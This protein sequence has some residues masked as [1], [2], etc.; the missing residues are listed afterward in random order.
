MYCK[1]RECL[2]SYIFF[3]L[4]NHKCLNVLFSVT[5]LIDRKELDK[6]KKEKE[7]KLFEMVKYEEE[8]FLLVV[9]LYFIFWDNSWIRLVTQEILCCLIVFQYQKIKMNVKDTRRLCLKHFNKLIQSKYCHTKT[10]KTFQ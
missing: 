9:S 8:C 10:M 7:K 5:N 3:K 2:C 1:L 6:S 4:C